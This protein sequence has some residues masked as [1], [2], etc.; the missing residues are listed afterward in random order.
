MTVAGV[1]EYLGNA[2]I[3]L[4]LAGIP[5][6]A[7]LF[8][9][10]P[11]YEVFVAGAKEGF[12]VFLRV[13]PYM[14]AMLVAVGMLR[15][16]GTFDLLEQILRPFLQSVGIPGDILPVML[17]RPFSGSGATAAVADLLQKHGGDSF[18]SHMGVVV[19]GTTEATFYIIAVYFGAAG[20]R[21]TRYAL[22]VSLLVDVVGLLTAIWVTRWLL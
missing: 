19:A 6:Y 18:I 11:V 2:L 8:K 20:I 16:S 22:P 7:H 17:I 9:K 12:P 21:N 5:L 15:A 3:L 1:S 13:M 10:V 4:F 14:V